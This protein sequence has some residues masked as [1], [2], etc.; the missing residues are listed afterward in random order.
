MILPKTICTIYRL[1]SVFKHT[2]EPNKLYNNILN[3]FL[4][5]AKITGD[6]Y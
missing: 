6:F 4:S 5:F 2:F 1:V 3:V